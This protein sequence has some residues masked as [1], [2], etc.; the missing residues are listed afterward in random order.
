MQHSIQAKPTF[1]I[2]L[3]ACFFSSFFAVCRHFSIENVRYRVRLFCFF[4]SCLTFCFVVS[5]DVF[6]SFAYG[7]RHRKFETISLIWCTFWVAH[8][9]CTN[10][11]AS[12]IL[13]LINRKTYDLKPFNYLFFYRL[14]S[15]FVFHTKWIKD[16]LGM[17]EGPFGQTA[18]TKKLFDFIRLKS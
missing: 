9:R 6:T 17:A 4:F 8:R 14:L 1:V 5:V 12:N 16:C 13:I 11:S 18:R 3:A 10:L 7:N 2:E 15:V